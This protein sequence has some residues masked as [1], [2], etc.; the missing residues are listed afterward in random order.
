MWHQVW[1]CATVIPVLG[2]QEDIKFETSLGCITLVCLTS[3]FLSFPL[4]SPSVKMVVLCI[5]LIVTG[6]TNKKQVT[7]KYN[8][9]EYVLIPWEPEKLKVASCSCLRTH[10]FDVC[11]LHV[12]QKGVLATL[13]LEGMWKRKIIMSDHLSSVVIHKVGMCFMHAQRTSRKKLKVPREGLT[14]LSHLV[15]IL[16]VTLNYDCNS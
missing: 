1:W 13:Y 14:N 10:C 6:M 11:P 12:L 2:R 3:N 7:I 16:T 9:S 15:S 5:L 4:A 8:S